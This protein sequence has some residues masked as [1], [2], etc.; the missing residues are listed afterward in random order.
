[1]GVVYKARHLGLNR[2]VALKMI[3]TGEHADQE[4]RV[5]LR[6][7]AEAVARLHHPNIVQTR[8]RRTRRPAVLLALEFVRWRR[9]EPRFSSTTPRCRPW[10]RPGY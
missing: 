10:M 4:E 7:E 5:L 1:M 2:V 6:A 9:S 3:L 8:N